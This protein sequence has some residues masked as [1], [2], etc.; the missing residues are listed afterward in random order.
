MVAPRSNPPVRL[1]VDL[2]DLGALVPIVASTAEIPA[3]VLG[4]DSGT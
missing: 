1:T 3:G 4:R 2:L